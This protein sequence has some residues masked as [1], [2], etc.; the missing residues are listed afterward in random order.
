MLEELRRAGTEPPAAET[1]PALR[2]LLKRGQAVAA[3]WGLFAAKEAAD[4]VLEEIKA[5]CREEGEISLS[6]L[7]DR[8]GTSRK[9]CPG[10]ARVRR[11]RRGNQPYG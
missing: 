11:R 7:R 6:G 4:G 2:L 1:T 5:V 9:F 8:L 10:V 3:G